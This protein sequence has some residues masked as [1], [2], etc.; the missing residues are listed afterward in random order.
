LLLKILTK[1][2]VGKPYLSN[3]PILPEENKGLKQKTAEVLFCGFL[4]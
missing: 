2:I 1:P 3:F 4:I